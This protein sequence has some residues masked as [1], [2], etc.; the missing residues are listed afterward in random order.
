[1]SDSGGEIRLDPSEEEGYPR[2][3]S[4][5]NTAEAVLAGATGGMDDEQVEAVRATLR[6]EGAE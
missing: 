5:M 1:M 3:P 4:G 2:Y 6:G